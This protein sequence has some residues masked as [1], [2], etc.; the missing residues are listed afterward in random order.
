M[1]RRRRG[2]TPF[3]FLDRFPE[4]L[5]LVVGFDT[6]KSLQVHHWRNIIGLAFGAV[7]RYDS[8]LHAIPNSRVLLSPLFTQ[9]AV[10]S[11]RIEGTR[12]TMNEVLEFEANG[13]VQSPELSADIHE[14]LNYRRAMIEAEQMLEKLPVSLRVIRRAHGVLLDGVRGAS[15]P[16][17]A[18]AVGGDRAAAPLHQR[19]PGSSQ[20]RLLRSP[21]NRVA[22]SGLDRVGPFLPD[23][24]AN[25]GGGEPGEG[26][27]DC[28]ALRRSQAADAR[29]DPVSVFDGRAGLDLRSS[30]L[31]G[32][33]VLPAGPHT[34]AD[35][36]APARGAA[37]Q[38]RD[39]RPCAG[40]GTPVA[41]ARLPRPSEHCGR[42]AGL[43]TRSHR[44]RRPA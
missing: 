42:K 9:E 18:V 13:S 40:I 23:S 10:L 22:G 34:R 33:D 36:P 32:G 20:G 19:I 31:L 3:H 8:L 12:A 15:N 30:D 28:R 11:S 27:R 44:A 29:H 25:P 39:Q 4:R 1:N 16:V 6:R 43:L 24:R 14:I 35:R 17:A 2:A 38:R 26:A 21:S 5:A 41:A 37:R 7:A